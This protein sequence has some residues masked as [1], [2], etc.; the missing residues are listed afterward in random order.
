LEYAARGDLNKEIAVALGIRCQTVKNEFSRLMKKMGAKNRPHAVAL[1]LSHGLI[2]GLE[3]PLG[4]GA[5]LVTTTQGL[6]RNDQVPV[7]F[8]LSARGGE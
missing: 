5:A 1:G 4:E 6:S 7:R 8:S 3:D 2:S